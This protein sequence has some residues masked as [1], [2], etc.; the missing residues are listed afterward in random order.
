MLTYKEF[1][2]IN[3]P[4]Q[5]MARGH[6][7]SQQWKLSEPAMWLLSMVKNQGNQKGALQWLIN[8]G[9]HDA[10]IGRRHLADMASK[11]PE[12]GRPVEDHEIFSKA[13]HD[14]DPKLKAY[15]DKVLLR[16]WEQEYEPKI[17]P[18]GSKK[19][20]DV[21][22][23]NQYLTSVGLPAFKFGG[24]DGLI[25]W[26]EDGDWADKY[27]DDSMFKNSWDNRKGLDLSNP[28][29]IK[30]PS[31]GTE[32]Y[33]FGSNENP[34]GKFYPSENNGSYDQALKDTRRLSGDE[35]A[36]AT[37]DNRM[38]GQDEI[39][40]LS[41]SKDAPSLNDKTLNWLSQNSQSDKLTPSVD[42]ELAVRER[43]GISGGEAEAKIPDDEWDTVKTAIR[44]GIEIYNHQ[45]EKH[46]QRS[47][48]KLGIWDEIIK[49]W[50]KEEIDSI[51][52]Q[53]VNEKRKTIRDRA[54]DP[55]NDR[56]VRR[57]AHDHGKNVGD[58]GYNHRVVRH[59]STFLDL[60]IKALGIDS[61]K[62]KSLRN[63]NYTFNNTPL[64]VKSAGLKGHQ[65]YYTPILDSKKS[66][67]FQN[68]WFSKPEAYGDQLV[69]D[70]YV[71]GGSAYPSSL[72][73]AVK[74]SIGKATKM[75]VPREEA[76]RIISNDDFI[77]DALMAMSRYFGGW[78]FKY[79]DPLSKWTKFSDKL[80]DNHGKNIYTLFNNIGVSQ[81]VANDYINKLYE[82]HKTNKPLD[83]PKEVMDVFLQNGFNWRVNY[84]SNG[85]AEEIRRKFDQSRKERAGSSTVAG[86]SGEEIDPLQ[87][88]GD[89][90]SGGTQ[91]RDLFSSPDELQSRKGRVKKIGDAD[92]QQRVPAIPVA[93]STVQPS[94]TDAPTTPAIPVATPTTPA[95]KDAFRNSTTSFHKDIASNPAYEQRYQRAKRI[96]SNIVPDNKPSSYTTRM[97]AAIRNSLAG[98]SDIAQ[99]RA[100]I[101]SFGDQIGQELTNQVKN[102]NDPASQ[103]NSIAVIASI[104]NS[105]LN[106]SSPT[107]FERLGAQTKSGSYEDAEA[108]L[109][110]YYQSID[111]THQDQIRQKIVDIKRERE[112]HMVPAMP[113][114]GQGQPVTGGVGVNTQQPQAVPQQAY[115]SS[116]D[117]DD[118]MAAQR[119]AAQNLRNPE[120]ARRVPYPTSQAEHAMTTFKEWVNWKTLKALKNGS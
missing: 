28:S 107:G 68:N 96:F 10:A 72:I 62:L 56:E 32:Y 3:N 115:Y 12:V 2:N 117:D 45:K 102:L 11:A 36:R 75:G 1:V 48:D 93:G 46:F 80:E 55:I 89:R 83:F 59:P 91:I 33:S 29:H 31:T 79:G 24:Y 27:S 58:T 51:Y 77:S 70:K 39:D 63:I 49:P 88:V 100:I 95:I 109:E 86:K 94:S 7:N 116:D 78:P 19:G 113:T 13:A 85:V 26:L 87:N 47:K 18:V 37:K 92:I 110:D 65:G 34:S 64:L 42:Y 82:Y 111:K 40:G 112:S 50:S 97:T 14:A 61:S 103:A 99:A 52:N 98:V 81:D 5:E 15:Y 105:Y 23:I 16:K 8:Q 119:Q 22:Q 41:S 101:D 67:D 21:N 114:T 60:G 106:P 43:G 57:V 76:Q 108:S 73:Q 66:A 6:G 38:L 9:L 30:D 4:F 69:R 118:A 74:S 71:G 54:Y 20:I 120:A 104:V 17:I 35:I 90:E 44:K 53:I 84:A 25:E